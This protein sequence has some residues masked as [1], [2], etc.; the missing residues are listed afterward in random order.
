MTGLKKRTKRDLGK[1]NPRF[2]PPSA[3]G[4]RINFT[5]RTLDRLFASWRFGLLDELHLQKLLGSYGRQSH[6]EL[7]LTK[8]G[9]I[10]HPEAQIPLRAV[11]TDISWVT[12][13]SNKGADVL[14]AKGARI[15]PTAHRER[16]RRHKSYNAMLH[17]LN[18]SDFLV[19]LE[20]AVQSIAHKKGSEQ[21]SKLF[22]R[23]QDELLGAPY[24]ET[25][26]FPSMAVW[27]KE[28]RPLKIEPDGIFS[29]TLPE[30]PADRAEK[31]FALEIDQDTE[32]NVRY[33]NFWEQKSVLKT[34]IAYAEAHKRGIIADKLGF[35]NLRTLFV[36]TTDRHMDNIIKDAKSH[37][38]AQG[39]PPNAFLF[40]SRE[41]LEKFDPLSVE[42]KNAA[43]NSV[44]IT[45]L[46]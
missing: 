19:E 21:Y 37:Y 26:S 33:R 32:S 24:T 3:D 29:L 16:Y 9:L 25:I 7:E 17:D 4:H 6:R 42:Y 41:R 18:R 8:A 46:Y 38:I 2:K 22:I 10:Y 36:T 15:D 14:A 20:T 31:F 45:E 30:L 35:P 43:G 12:A 44:I 13:L 34:M 40:V 39:Y 27:K 5:Q 23:H 1:L 11:C 28:H